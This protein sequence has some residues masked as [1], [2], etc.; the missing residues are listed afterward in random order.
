MQVLQDIERAKKMAGSEWATAEHYF[1]EAPRTDEPTDPVIEPARIFDNV[2]AI[3]NSGTTAYV[4][5]TSE[6]L[7]MIDAL[8][9]NQLET[10]LLPGFQKLGLDPAQVKMTLVTHGHADRFGGA[11]YFQEHYG[12][13]VYIG[14]G[15][16]DLMKHPPARQGAPKGSAAVIP[17]HDM[18]IAEAQPIVLGD[19]TVMPYLVPPHTPGSMGLLFPV[20]DNG[21]THM[22]ALFGS[23]LLITTMTDDPGMQKHAGDCTFQRRSQER[24]G[25]RRTPESSLNGR[26]HGETG[27]AAGTETRTAESFRRGASWLSEI[28]GCHVGMH[29][30]G[31]R[32]AREALGVLEQTCA[33]GHSVVS[34]R[35]AGHA[36]VRAPS[37]GHF[38]AD[39]PQLREKLNS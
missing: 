2:Y 38:I 7:L 10:L 21:R 8:R 12:S 35:V 3:G 23:I 5:S 39:F 27:E 14:Q 25:G 15:D 26:L 13:H 34:N 32:P 11:A 30:G 20:K 4:I 17:K 28:S 18:V 1:C 29:A 19:E 9:P 16:W 24:D 31:N 36:V 33:L 6:G 37:I 22:A